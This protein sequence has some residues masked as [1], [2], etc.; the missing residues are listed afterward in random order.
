MQTLEWL[1]SNA[2]RR[3]PLVDD[4][5]YSYVGALSPTTSRT[6]TDDVLLD[7][8][9]ISYVATDNNIVFNGFDVLPGL[10]TSV[11]FNFTHYLNSAPLF[12]F[13][14]TV[15]G[16]AVFPYR[17]VKSVSKRYRVELWF[18]EGVVA[19]STLPTDSYTLNSPGI[20][21]TL[22]V[23][24]A[25][26]SVTSIAGTA[27][28]S[29]S[30]IK[31]VHLEEGANIGVTLN[32]I[33]NTIYIGAVPGSG[34]GLSCMVLPNS[35]TGSDYIKSLCNYKPDSRGNINLNAGIG[36]KIIPDKVNHRVIIK[37]TIDDNQI[38]CGK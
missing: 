28:D 37:S 21:G 17:I 26:W 3:Y 19:L 5:D 18:G 1:N 4:A 2:Y 32:T 6:F 34:S 16:S 13:Y 24:Q 25:G 38:F 15:P 36:F 35:R 9:Y 29:I 22:I 27:D 23:P 12:S 7:F 8:K 33:N 10:P 31:P 11:R 30:L 20:L 14:V